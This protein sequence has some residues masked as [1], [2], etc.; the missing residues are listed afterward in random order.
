MGVS[1]KMLLMVGAMMLATSNSASAR[2]DAWG[3]CYTTAPSYGTGS[4]SSY[5]GYSSRTGSQWGASTYGGTTRGYDGGGN[6][7]IYTPGRSYY[8]SGTGE[9]RS[10]SPFTGRRIR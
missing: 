2:C 4:G 1:M 5:N 7:Y 10:Y 3:N 9:T 6:N 8:N